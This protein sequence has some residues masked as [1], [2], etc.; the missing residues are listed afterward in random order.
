MKPTLCCVSSSSQFPYLR[1][2]ADRLIKETPNFEEYETFF[3]YSAEIKKYIL[4][5]TKDPIKRDK[6]SSRT[7][8]MKTSIFLALSSILFCGL[9]YGSDVCKQNKTSFYFATGSHELNESDKARLDS[10]ASVL[11]ERYYV[12]LHGYT[13]TT[14]SMSLNMQLSE[15]RVNS[16]HGRLKINDI[17]RFWRGEEEA[18]DD[19]NPAMSRRVDLI[20]VP[21]ANNRLKLVGEQRSSIEIPLESFGERSICSCELDLDE[22]RNDDEALNADVPLMSTDS[23]QLTTGG[24]VQLHSSADCLEQC[25]DS[26]KVTIPWGIVDREMTTWI[27]VQTE[28][29]LRWSSSEFALKF[30]TVNNIYTI[31]IPCEPWPFPLWLNL[32]KP[33]PLI[34]NPRL[35]VPELTRWSE[36]MASTPEMR[37]Y[38]GDDTTYFFDYSELSDTTIIYDIGINQNCELY[39][40]KDTLAEYTWKGSKF[41]VFPEDYKVLECS[42]TT[43]IVKT[44][45]DFK[46]E[47]FVDHFEVGIDNEIYRI[48]G[49]FFERLLRLRKYIIPLPTSHY[50]FKINDQEIGKE[51]LL[52]RYNKKRKRYKKRL[53]Q[54]L[55]KT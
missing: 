11:K 39:Y 54:D 26:V 43:L 37:I 13:D 40:F 50:S 4:S 2:Q 12:E 8:Q 36:F 17:K 20:Y 10:L 28:A 51:L 23:V 31:T 46:F 21:I 14:G 44:K 53:K 24:M 3:N 9:I 49:N 55:L 18:T 6:L 1:A 30:D 5:N 47:T 38:R 25:D 48:K 42:D 34:T 45:S 7:E 52:E 27:A 41:K 35:L 29:G 19:E 22:I 15:L 16:V 32:D 33:L